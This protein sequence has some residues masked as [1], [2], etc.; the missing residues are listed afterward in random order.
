MGGKPDRQAIVSF[1]F[2]LKVNAM[3]RKPGKKSGECPASDCTA[4]RPTQRALTDYD[5]KRI[6]EADRE[7][8]GKGARICSYCSCVYTFDRDL[9]QNII[10]GWLDSTQLGEGWHPKAKRL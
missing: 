1:I 6:P 9:Q 7:A 2:D 8:L 3:A 5:L 4:A 10:R